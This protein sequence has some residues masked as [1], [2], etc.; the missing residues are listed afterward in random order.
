MD[1]G[2][3]S[4]QDLLDHNAFQA[5]FPQQPQLKKPKEDIKG[6]GGLGALNL[7]GSF[8]TSLQLAD[9]PQKWKG[10]LTVVR[11]LGTPLIFSAATMKKMPLV[12][13]LG[14]STAYVGP[15]SYR[16]PLQS[17]AEAKAPAFHEGDQLTQEIH[18]V[19]SQENRMEA[20]LAADVAIPPGQQLL[21]PVRATGKDEA[22]VI[23]VPD[24]CANRP[25]QLDPV[26][27]LCQLRPEKKGRQTGVLIQNLT[28]QRRRLRAGQLVGHFLTPP[29]EKSE[30]HQVSVP[31]K[32][33]AEPRYS[34]LDPQRDE[35]EVREMLYR[36]LGRPEATTAQEDRRRKE[37]V[38]QLFQGRIES[39][40]ELT[41]PEKR[42]VNDLLLRFY[43]ILSKSK[44]DVGKTNLLEFTVDT[45][46]HP[47]VRDRLRPMNPAIRADFQRSTQEMIEGEI[48]ARCHGQWASAVVPVRKADGSWRYAVDYR[49]LN[50]ITQHDSTPVA[51]PQEAMTNALL[52]EARFYCSADLT[53]AYLAVP[54]KESDQEKL[55]MVTSLGL[56]KYLRM[57]FGARNSGQT[58]ARLMAL[59]VGDLVRQGKILSFFDDHLVTG[60]S[61]LQTLF[62]LGE[63]FFEVERANLRVS[64]KKTHLFARKAV[65]L[66]HEVTP[67]SLLPAEKLTQ[68]VQEWPQPKSRK[69]VLTFLGK[70]SYYRKF[71][72]HFAEKAEPLRK[73]LGKDAV[74]EWTEK[75]EQAFQRLKDALCAKPVLA[76]P[77]FECDRPF[78]LD[79]DAS[80]VGVGAVL[81][82]QQEDGAEKPIAYFSKTL[83]SA[84]KN[85]SVTRREL[86]AIVSA[87]KNF[88]YF[89]IG[90]PF[91]IRTDHRALEWLTK[92]T[93]VS[94]QL[95]RWAEALKDFQFEIEYRP[96]RAHTNAD[97]LSR[98]EETSD[99][100][101]ADLSPTDLDMYR[102]LRMKPPSKVQKGDERRE[103]K[104]G[105]RQTKEGEERQLAAVQTRRQKRAAEAA[106]ETAEAAT[107][108][109]EEDGGE[110]DPR[111]ERES[112]A[113]AAEPPA[114]TGGSEE[115]GGEKPE[116]LCEEETGLEKSI[117]KLVEKDELEGLEW[118][119]LDEKREPALPGT[120]D[121]A[122]EQE[123]DP[124]LQQVRQWMKMKQQPVVKEFADPMLRTYAAKR[125]RLELEEDKLYLREGERRRLCIP[126]HLIADL[127]RCLHNHPLAGHVGRTRCYLQARR[128]FYW[129]GMPEHINQFIAGC[130][131]C[132]RAK[133]KK[134]EPKV[135]LGQTSTGM[136]NRFETFYCDIVGPWPQAGN[137][138]EAKRYLLT[139]QCAVTKW[140]EAWPLSRITAES[141]L[142]T[143]ATQLLP[144][145]GTGFTLITDRGRQFVS[146]LFRRAAARL[147]VITAT[148]QAYE[149]KSN[150][151]ER[152][153]RTIEGH[154][155]ALMEAE[156]AHP[157]QWHR[158]VPY[159]LAAMRQ[160]PLTNLPASPHYLV[161]GVEPGIPAQQLTRHRPEKGETMDI[162]RD[163]ARLERVLDR[164][165]LQQLRNHE[166]NKAH[167]DRRLK[168]ENLKE[169]DWCWLHAGQDT[170]ESGKSRKTAVFMEGPYRVTRLLN[171]RQVQ[172]ATRTRE[173][174]QGATRTHYVT[175]SRDRVTKASRFELSR[176]PAPLSWPTARR[177]KVKTIPREYTRWEE[178]PR[179]TIRVEGMPFPALGGWPATVPRRAPPP[180][181]QDAAVGPE[182]PPVEPG[183]ALIRPPSLEEGMNSP[184]N[185]DAMW[186]SGEEVDEMKLPGDND[187]MW[188]P[189]RE[190]FYHPYEE[191]AATIP[192]P[193]DDEQMAGQGGASDHEAAM[194]EAKKRPRNFS[195][196][197]DVSGGSTRAQALPPHKRR[198]L[199][200]ERPQSPPGEPTKPTSSGKGFLKFASDILAP[201]PS[202]PK[203]PD[204]GGAHCLMGNP[205]GKERPRSQPG[206]AKPAYFLKFRRVHDDA[207]PPV[208]R[209]PQ[210]V[211]YDLSAIEEVKVG[212]WET[213]RIGTG[214]Q[215]LP[216]KG[217]YIRLASRSGLETRRGLGVV[218]GVIDRD[219]RG[220]VTVVLRNHLRVPQ[221]VSKGDYIA[222]AILERAAIVPTK[223]VKSLPPTERGDRGWGST[224]EKPSKQASSSSC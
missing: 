139:C 19:M 198:E 37:H 46:D 130:S 183:G 43:H 144:R 85:Y 212:A 65:W 71:I 147:G 41:S 9:Y 184:R 75:Q 42:L 151:V 35:G 120:Y 210:A 44:Y 163:M 103:K 18:V 137:D 136:T 158:F 111:E 23:F 66:G 29:A 99:G 92:S 172:L 124:A 90:R 55:A 187:A 166:A 68:A 182:E 78:I 119:E 179:P 197:S 156:S 150:P 202:T 107:G 14:T 222:Q 208:R 205:S 127:V 89:L 45:G 12:L 204:P 32:K 28:Q 88:K 181:Q 112:T 201:G 169:G 25:T 63:F 10:R 218:A 175:V 58:Y 154:I 143:L 7:M 193:S 221:T 114:E 4:K 167:Y 217:T 199:A 188:G 51:S 74:F 152:M 131:P 161:Y 128:S 157:N 115:K 100:E 206:D 159:A 48:I 165:R 207:K 21:V 27:G 24:S 17:S 64:P 148:T 20:R 109:T 133:R 54:V 101:V 214:L 52:R 104:L 200:E 140:P 211:G 153:H 146:A 177:Y 5:C 105:G 162:D 134:V 96:G 16:V 132:A 149:P 40:S 15:S 1:T 47:P 49:Q 118:E 178:E 223:E 69:D 6:P 110:P 219:Y 67:D 34:H 176:I 91:V 57:P 84:E 170:S 39:N 138:A 126:Q 83:S 186:D 171:D 108:L 56:Y 121:M 76:H 93:T 196:L 192:L 117:R 31:R 26:P 173:D 194:S 125:S 38:R 209:T 73:L 135:P 50:K 224:D 87:A 13:D 11:D 94:A 36:F 80:N 62:R 61:F 216:P 77:D 53:G 129:P 190:P 145:F 102:Q 3:L 220:E 113:A 122:R 155:R 180:P 174:K 70:C 215:L 168:R 116:C 59:T 185:S 22:Q 97:A 123:R 98:R 203:S 72:A 95:A 79:C 8:E 2:N 191:E 195:P 30:L 141:V 60:K 33:G 81:S 86:L 106:A 213:A 189:P 164:V 160:N 142:H 82:Q